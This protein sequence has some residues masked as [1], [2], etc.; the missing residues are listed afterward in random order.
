MAFLRLIHVT[1]LHFGSS[2]AT[3]SLW[4]QTV[5]QVPGLG[6][7]SER[8]AR[9]LD[10]AVKSIQ[11]AAA[12][13]PTLV[14]ATGDLTTWGT[15]AGF[16]LALSYL[17]GNFYAGPPNV[18]VGLNQ[19]ALPVIAGNHDVWGG[20]LLGVSTNASIPPASRPAY[21]YAFDKPAPGAT[22]PTGLS[23]PYQVQLATGQG[24]DVYLYGLESNEGT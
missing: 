19:P 7:H 9:E 8:V 13:I 15:S 24:F 2:F 12:G 6:E 21:A 23:F 20:W 3:P 18:M 4:A 17:R 5:A 14:V 1:D 22:Y 10:L 16:N 11:L